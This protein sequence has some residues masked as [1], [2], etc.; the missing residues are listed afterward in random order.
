[1]AEL[2]GKPDAAE[3][4]NPTTNPEDI[5]WRKEP[6]SRL[7]P[8]WIFRSTI[9]IQ[10]AV[11]RWLVEDCRRLLELEPSMPSPPLAVALAFKRRLVHPET[12]DLDSE[13]IAAASIVCGRSKGLTLGPVTATFFEYIGKLPDDDPTFELLKERYVEVATEMD[14]EVL[15]RIHA[16]ATLPSEAR[17][18]IAEARYTWGAPAEDVCAAIDDKFFLF[19]GSQGRIEELK[20]HAESIFTARIEFCTTRQ[21]IDALFRDVELEFGNCYTALRTRVVQARKNHKDR[22][23]AEVHNKFGWPPKGSI[24]VLAPCLRWFA[25]ELGFE[26]MSVQDFLAAA[27]REM[28]RSEKT[29]VEALAPIDKTVSD[30]RRRLYIERNAPKLIKKALQEELDETIADA[31]D[32][33]VRWREEMGWESAAVTK[34]MCNIASPQVYLQTCQAEA[35]DAANE[36]RMRPPDSADE[37]EPRLDAACRLWQALELLEAE[38]ALEAANEYRKEFAEELSAVF[39]FIQLLRE[40]LL[41]VEEEP[42]GGWH[43]PLGYIDVDQPVAPPEPPPP[44]YVPTPASSTE[45]PT[46]RADIICTMKLHSVAVEDTKA[47]SEI[48]LIEKLSSIIAEECGVP[49]HW[50]GGLKFQTVK[51]EKVKQPEPPSRAPAAAENDLMSELDEP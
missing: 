7:D 2:A 38:G 17:A 23:E 13:A 5:T 1:M 31:Q 19:S 34:I 25:H 21:S 49:R 42:E 41:P 4:A 32:V 37:E 27:R 6:A 45:P 18:F 29:A 22:M 14:D 8:P 40:D 30:F 43:R 48:L 26:H 10:A 20:K 44:P 33:I 50:V 36:L 9:L 46:P 12:I 15:A 28:R 51:T 16:F 35:S 39:P 24:R 47:R 11:R 3:L